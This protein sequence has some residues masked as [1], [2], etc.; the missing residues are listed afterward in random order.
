MKI[1]LGGTSVSASDLEYKLGKTIMAGI[2]RESIVLSKP[3]IKAL[4][5]EISI[6]ANTEAEKLGDKMVELMDRDM[7]TVDGAIDALSYQDLMRGVTLPQGFSPVGELGQGEVLVWFGLS[8]EYIK[9]KQREFSSSR[10]SGESGASR[11]TRYPPERMF[12]YTGRLRSYFSTFGESF[13]R[14]RLGGVRVKVKTPDELR[15]T[16]RRG[17]TLTPEISYTRTPQTTYT[18][19]KLGSYR[20]VLMG[21][22]EVT[23]FPKV[24]SNLV[25]LLASG[26]W[27]DAFQSHGEFERQVL[28]TADGDAMLA[29]IKLTN[30]DR[31]YRP[32]L[33]PVVQFW[34]QIRI[35]AMIFR[36]LQNYSRRRSTYVRGT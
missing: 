24:D 31:P 17:M 9:R 7:R 4:A 15:S 29:A 18:G 13:V 20:D 23:I 5:A 14:N 30:R 11:R 35:P 25:P 32:L 8:Q 26:S 3:R 12:E 34:M 33:L 1:R 10:L 27:M 22:I 36:T 2:E 28:S 6:V 19:Q 21:A 16:S